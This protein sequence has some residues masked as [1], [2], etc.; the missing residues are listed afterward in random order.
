MPEVKQNV[1]LLS[2]TPEPEKLIATAARL[3]YSK[4]DVKGLLKEMKDK[5]TQ[6]FLLM[7]R[8]KG[9]LSTFEHASFSFVIEGVS[10]SLTHQLVRHRLC[11]F[12]QASQRYI[13]MTKI[14]EEGEKLDDFNWIIPKSA[15]IGINTVNFVRSM[16]NSYKTYAN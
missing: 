7:L 2:H 8:N 12:S 13:D 1:I 10:R 14:E 5:E 11:S 3:C 16:N 6:D 4:T 15:D 9:H